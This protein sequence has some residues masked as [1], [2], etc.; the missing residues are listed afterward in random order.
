[1]SDNPASDS[2]VH[3]HPVNRAGAALDDVVPDEKLA[4]G[5]AA[6]RFWN[7]FS[8]AGGRFHAGQWQSDAG[9]RR[10]VYTETELCVIL[11]GRVR[12]TD[13]AGKAAEFGAGEAFVVAPGF[14][15]TWE[16]IGRVTKVYAVLEPGA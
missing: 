10:V 2:P 15:G 12:L 11:E 16:L 3:V 1:M 6:A 4:G 9:V 7:A 8:G 14:R 13:T 5:A